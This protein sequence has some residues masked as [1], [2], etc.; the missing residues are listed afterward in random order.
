MNR[1]IGKVLHNFREQLTGHHRAAFLLNERGHG[2]LN[3]EL[4]VGGLRMILSPAASMRIPD[5]TGS[6]D[7]VETP[8]RT[9]DR[10]L[11]S[12]VRL[13]LNFKGCSLR[14]GLS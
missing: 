1:S 7:R 11:A 14:N 4:Q 6:V 3:G 12:S 8:L 2:V 13:I 5:K 9:M 10:A